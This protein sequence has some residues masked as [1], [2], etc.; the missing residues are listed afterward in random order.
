[1]THVYICILIII[2]FKLIVLILLM[3]NLSSFENVLEVL[4]TLSKCVLPTSSEFHLS[5][6]NSIGE[7]HKLFQEQTTQVFKA[8]NQQITNAFQMINF[9]KLTKILI[10]VRMH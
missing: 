6:I 7:L 1:M 5:F 10:F 8:I 9:I 2:Y 4:R 3:N